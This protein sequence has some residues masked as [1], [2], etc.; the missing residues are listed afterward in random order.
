[1][2]QQHIVRAY[3]D[4]LKRLNE[5][6]TRMGG[7]AENQLAGAMR[8]VHEHDSELA[9]QV[10]EA[11]AKVDALEQEADAFVVQLLALRQPMA[12]DLRVIVGALKISS[13]LERIADYATN[14][15]K[16]MVTLAQSPQLPPAHGIPRMGQIAQGMIKDVLDA[17]QTGD[18]EKAM[19]VW[20][21]DEEVDEAY[22]S[23]FRELLTY[24]M[25]DVRSISTCAHLLF[26]AKNIERIGDHA[27]NIAENIYF[28]VNGEAL[29][30]VR[31][32]GVDHSVAPKAPPDAGGGQANGGSD[33]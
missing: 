2:N 19:D 11:D 22:N 1:M 32:K 20:Q 6:I 4:D 18:A 9:Q 17:F 26:M 33:G 25:E 27:T 3:D 28:M 10:V 29:L 13:M 24:M 21:R 5:I 30:D 15:A 8:A 16:R 7:L 12:S 14:V 31:P 23:L